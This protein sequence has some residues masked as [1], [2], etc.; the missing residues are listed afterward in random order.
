LRPYVRPHATLIWVATSD[1][2]PLVYIEEYKIPTNIASPQKCDVMGDHLTGPCIFPQRL[3]GFIYA[4]FLQ[5][6]L[7]GPPEKVSLRARRQMYY[8][9]DGEPPHL[10]R[11]DTQH[12]KQF[13]DRWLGRGGAQNWPPR[14]SELN[15]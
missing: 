3:T 8:R 10:I 14:S 7:P 9:H 1:W 13:P 4:S 2:E 11:V 12:L 5:D 15:Q 6:V